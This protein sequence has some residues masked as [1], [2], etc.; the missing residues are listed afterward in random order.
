MP[1][2]VRLPHKLESIFIGP[3][4]YRVA[5]G[6]RGSG[7]SVGFAD[8]ALIDMVRDPMRFLCARELQNSI[9]DSVHNLLIQ[10]MSKLGMNDLFDHGE[11]FIRRR[12]YPEGEFLFKGLRTNI[13]EIKSMNNVKRCWVEEAQS[14]SRRSLEILLPTIRAPGSEIWFTFNPED[15]QDPVYQDFVV[16]KPPNCKTVKMNWDDNPW[17]PDELDQE[18]LRC[19]EHN[20]GRYDY[21][22]NGNFNINTEASVYAKWVNA[23]E[24]AGAFRSDLF[25]PS[26]PVH[27]AWDIGYSDYTSIWWFQVARGEVRVIDFYQNNREGIQHYCEQLLGYRY[28]AV[29]VDAKGKIL[30]QKGEEI[31]ELERRRK[32]RYLK[33]W[34]PHDA[35]HKLFAANGRSIV[36][37]ADDFNI[38]MFVIPAISQQNQI[39]VARATLN[40]TWFDPTYCEE[41]IRA[42][43]KYEFDYDDDRQ[44]YKD[45]PYHD[46]HS[47]AADA[48]ELLS[49]VWK[50]PTIESDKPKP[51]FLEDMTAK[52]LFWPKNDAGGHAKI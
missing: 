32:Y 22:W 23:R 29:G 45:E 41:G 20:P 52:E 6:G 1:V 3:A 38:R 48:F 7:K 51:R 8:M 17:F 40:Q 5:F 46:I 10:E 28:E 34:V 2:R 26:L 35:A 37:Q 39:E 12:G 16:N 44:K 14:T 21:I 49:Q 33:H 13:N 11:S 50:S 47:H 19:L 31:P 24:K 42:L 18:R 9:K 27:T 43:R 25:D 4:R 30:W 15:E 36:Q